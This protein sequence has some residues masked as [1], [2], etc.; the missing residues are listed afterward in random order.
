MWFL[1]TQGDF[2]TQIVILTRMSVIMTLKSAITTR[3]SVIDTRTNWISTFEFQNI[4]KN[5]INT[6]R[7]T[8][9]RI[10]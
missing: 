7:V 1:H 8:L 2:Y 3:T 5:W 10:N 6:M 9:K 4:K